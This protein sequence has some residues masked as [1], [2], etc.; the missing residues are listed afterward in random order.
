VVQQKIFTISILRLTKCF[1]IVVLT[2]LFSVRSWPQQTAV[3]SPVGDGA[4]AMTAAIAELQQQVRELRAAV[5]D[6]R[7]EAAQY[8]AETAELRDQLARD[9]NNERAAE[10]NE[11]GAESTPAHLQSNRAALPSVDSSAGKNVDDD[12]FSLLSGKIDEL[13]QTKIESGSKYKVRLS[14]IVLMNLFGNRGGV[15]SLDVPSFAMPK[16]SYGTNSSFGA[17]LRQSEFGLEVFG[18]EIA[19]AKISGSVQADFSGGLANTLNGANYGLVR[20]RTA[21]MRMDWKDTSL[22]A[23]QDNLFF[24]PQSPTSFASLSIPAFGYAGNLWGWIPQIR[25]EHRSM[26]SERQTLTFQGGVLDNFS[27]EPPYSTYDR[28]SQAGERSGQPAYAGRVAWSEIVHGSPLSFGAAGY[29]TRQNWGFNHNIDGWS[30]MADWNIPIIP[31]FSFSGEFYRGRAI[32]GLGGGI[33][34][35]IIYTGDPRDPATLIRG[36]SSIGGWS[37]LKFKPLDKL[38]FNGAFGIDNPLA[39]D[40]TGFAGDLS[41]YGSALRQNRS[42]LFNFILRPRSN[43]LFSAEY[44]HLRTAQNYSFS[45]TADQFNLMMGV[46]F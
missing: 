38:E 42:A 12:T 21:S 34:Q 23:G 2:I 3:P 31:R 7:S 8:R 33:G 17:T 41:I 40:F 28:S 39:R 11:H 5:A 6:M 29:Y 24:S 45:N 18:P 10:T 27:G 35:S 26:L 20:L 4:G 14:G 16:T 46:L 43:V 9:R 13:H 22:V 1:G 30:G 19:G 37:Q 25:L 44:R 15:D 32:G 36:L